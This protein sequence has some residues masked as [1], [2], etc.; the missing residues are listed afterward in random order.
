MSK[1]FGRGGYTSFP[2]VPSIGTSKSEPAIKLDHG[3]DGLLDSTKNNVSTFVR[4]VVQAQAAREKNR[5]VASSNQGLDKVL[6]IRRMTDLQI[7]SR[8]G[9]V[10]RDKEVESAL[11]MAQNH[12]EQTIMEKEMVTDQLHKRNAHIKLLEKQ[13]DRWRAQ[14]KKECT[15]RA[16]LIDLRQAKKLMN[17]EVKSARN[18][19]VKAAG[20]SK[21]LM[22]TVETK[23][24]THHAKIT[25]ETNAYRMRARAE[26][27][28][29][30][31]VSTSHGCE[32][33]KCGWKKVSMYQK[34]EILDIKQKVKTLRQEI[35]AKDIRRKARQLLLYKRCNIKR[36]PQICGREFALPLDPKYIKVVK[37][38]KEKQVAKKPTIGKKR[39]VMPLEQV[40][41]M[42]YWLYGRKIQSDYT[43]DLRNRPR[44]DL[45]RIIRAAFA[46]R[47]GS[48]QDGNAEFKE[49]CS[50]LTSHCTKDAFVNL[51]GRVCGYIKLR[52]ISYNGRIGHFIANALNRLILLS[53]NNKTVDRVCHETSRDLKDSID[54]GAMVATML[55]EGDEEGITI[56]YQVAL[57]AI[58]AIFPCRSSH[59]RQ[60][61]HKIQLSETLRSKFYCELRK[62]YGI[63]ENDGRTIH[64]VRR[65]EKIDVSDSEDEEAENSQPQ[66]NNSTVP[67]F[68]SL[69]Q[70]AEPAAVEL[71]GKSQEIRAHIGE[72]LSDLD[73]DKVS[74]VKIKQFRKMFA[75]IGLRLEK[76]E[77]I[78]MGEKAGVVS[79][80]FID[81][82]IFLQYC[83]D[84]KKRE[85]ARVTYSMNRTKAAIVIQNAIRIRLR[86]K[87]FKDLNRDERAAVIIQSQVRSYLIR[88]LYTMN[89][90]GTLEVSV[91]YGYLKVALEDLLGLMLK[92]FELQEAE[93]KK[94]LSGLFNSTRLDEDGAVTLSQ[95]S[96]IVQKCTEQ[97]FPSDVIAELFELASEQSK[98]LK[99]H[100][101]EFVKVLVHFGVYPPFA[102]IVSR[103]DFVNDVANI[104]H[105]KVEAAM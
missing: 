57:R 65:D 46:T 7:A 11:K 75:G 99:V 4:D 42:I 5:S 72:C 38:K 69:D 34:K 8:S 91:R 88:R 33:V 12:L 101:K 53:T 30:V 103:E 52:K 20:T 39:D 15:N 87:R 81:Y 71:V 50:G 85:E 13:R 90:R 73:P 49:F 70:M 93:N 86:K 104:F 32:F 100:E 29:K 17:S 68:N 25:S 41:G 102:D 62:M 40:K 22:N 16:E 1:T 82:N 67:Q 3:D 76:A 58:H 94:R 83:K 2:A 64:H 96:G 51:F 43:C 21:E 84:I 37:K 48:L 36:Y 26:I 105:K 56:N 9:A 61:V 24:K 66:E 60:S 78:S 23:W 80:E 19:A 95:F 59:L 10:Q 27:M 55:E 54:F 63:T 74:V 45:L 97:L 77:V 6:A 18:L 92:Y 28:W 14:Y 47:M 44:T 79:E 35:S 89:K 31:D 98:D